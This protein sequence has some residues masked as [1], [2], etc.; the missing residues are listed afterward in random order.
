MHMQQH[1]K[2]PHKGHIRAARGILTRH[3][4]SSVVLQQHFTAHPQ[5]TTAIECN[6]PP[7]TY[8]VAPYLRR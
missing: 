6:L 3:D 7:T 4:H 1:V 8:R 5:M 2:G